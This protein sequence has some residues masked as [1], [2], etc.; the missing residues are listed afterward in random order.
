MYASF[1]T[2]YTILFILTPFMFTIHY[3]LT[4]TRGY[5][6]KQLD[7]LIKLAYTSQ[8]LKCKN[9]TP[10]YMHQAITM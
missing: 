1:Y 6:Q 5:K 10:A 4:A 7:E 2:F 3:S 9:L 8:L